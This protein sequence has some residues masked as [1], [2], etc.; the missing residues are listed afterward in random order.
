MGK[1]CLTGSIVVKH[2]TLIG[3][4]IWLRPRIQMF[5]DAL[6]ARSNAEVHG[7]VL[8][9][10]GLIIA[11]AISGFFSF[12]YRHS[13]DGGNSNSA[14][15]SLIIGHVATSL[16]L[17]VIG[18]LLLVSVSSLGNY[19]ITT[20]FGSYPLIIACIL[21]VSLVFHDIYGILGLLERGTKNSGGC[22]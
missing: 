21:Y 4:L 18:M 12:G 10:C 20:E 8:T 3:A 16:Q 15:V 14:A 5:I 2:G 13:K 17:L 1:I 19:S 9:V 6:A 11:G 7:L 22:E